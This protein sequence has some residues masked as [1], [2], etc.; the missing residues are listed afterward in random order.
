MKLKIYTVFDQAV[1][2]YMPPF[3]MRS[4][5]EAI[6]AFT[7]SVL[8]EGTAMNAHPKDFTLFHNGAFDES[9]GMVEPLDTPIALVKG[10]EVAIPTQEIE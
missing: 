8:S 9:N 7:D 3:T 1:E 4:H 10:N 5:G 6:R 2:A